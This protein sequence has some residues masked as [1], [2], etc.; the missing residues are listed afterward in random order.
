MTDLVNHRGMD[1]SGYYIKDNVGMGHKRLAIIDVSKEGVQPFHHHH[2]PISVIF[3]GE[4]YNYIEIREELKTL[5]YHFKTNTDTEVLLASYIAWGEKCLSRFSGMWAF[6]IFD[7][8]DQ[9]VLCARDRFGI[10]P[11]YYS[12]TSDGFVFGSEI[13]QILPFLSKKTA[14]TELV[15]DFLVC[16][17]SDHH[18]SKTFFSGVFKLPSSYYLKIKTQNFRSKLVCYYTL[19]PNLSAVSL[20]HAEAKKELFRLIE[21]SMKLHLR[22]DVS[23]GTCLSGGLDS[24][25]VAAIASQHYHF[26][27]KSFTAITAISE[28]SD[29]NEEYYAKIVAKHLD[30]EWITTKP[31]YTDFSGNFIDILNTQ[32]EPFGGPSVVM[33]YF[34]MQTAKKYGIK[35]L[36]DG[37]GGDELFLGYDRY[38]AAWLISHWQKNGIKGFINAFL[39]AS[40]KHR[41]ISPINLL[42]N[43]IGNSSPNIRNLAYFLRS[44]ILRHPKI[45][46]VFRELSYSSNNSRE[47]QILEITKTN[48][49]M[50]LRFEDKNSMH[51]GVEARVPF[52][53]HQIVEFAIGLPPEFK[54]NN[55]WKKWP[56]RSIMNSFLPKEISWRRDKIGFAAPDKNWFSQH[57]STMDAQILSNELINNH[58]KHKVLKKD[59]K[60][61]NA[62]IKWNLFC[63]AAWSNL[64]SVDPE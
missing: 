47:V 63:V 7:E 15:N 43:L 14:D 50:L 52:L 56:L 40:A 27:E 26:P 58:T 25:S 57:Q 5:G 8:R 18:P 60:N 36:L 10:K 33:Q 30:I 12:E 41:D 38:Y 64:F 9:T 16:G 11:F 46:D 24:S 49:P 61:I 44:N 3:N 55:G 37:Q 53:D 28:Q 13:K 32:E 1:G 59:L 31:S 35:V 19:R 4:I 29:N 22:S 51:F 48:L 42:S 23:V 21:N 62:K 20:D 17:L 45:P 34:V 2:L 39:S 6:A 54:I